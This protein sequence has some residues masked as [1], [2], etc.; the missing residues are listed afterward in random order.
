MSPP[1][2]GG[3]DVE[4]EAI[5]EVAK[6][7]LVAARTSPKTAG[8]DDILASVVYGSEK[9]ALADKMK[10]IA[11]ER[12]I[13]AFR[14]DARNVRD[15]DAVILIGIRGSK[16]IG[17]NCGGCGFENCKQF[18][19]REKKH[20][21]DF[22]GPTCIFKGLDLGIALGSAVKIA[23]ILNVDNRIMYR[24]GTAAVR[25]KLLPEATIVMGIPV[26]AHGKSIYFDRSR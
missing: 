12:M 21:I 6:F 23:S 24:I 11:R 1:T 25:L 15:S 16:S 8:I 5:L 19:E 26:S 22:L 14:R 4:K 13:E 17:L 3:K 18:D 7:M 20:G 10:Q 2:I 9:D